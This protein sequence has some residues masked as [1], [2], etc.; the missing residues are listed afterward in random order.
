MT[1][2][3]WFDWSGRAACVDGVLY[4]ADPKLLLRPTAPLSSE[5]PATLA[6]HKAVP[7]AVKP[8]LLPLVKPLSSPPTTNLQ[9]APEHGVLQHVR[10][11]RRPGSSGS[12]GGSKQPLSTPELDRI[13]DWLTSA[14]GPAAPSPST[15]AFKV[16]LARLASMQKVS[17]MQTGVSLRL[18]HFLQHAAC[19]LP[20]QSPGKWPPAV[21]ANPSLQVLPI[22][23]NGLGVRP[24]SAGGL[25]S[26]PATR[27]AGAAGGQVGPEPSLAG[28]FRTPEMQMLGVA[29]FSPNTQ[30]S[31]S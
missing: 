19:S 25:P 8:A 2:N 31:R 27:T 7:R 23:S 12:A 18:C 20:S 30:V 24:G 14:S 21:T 29:L 4:D 9:L 28:M 3:G 13:M 22:H 15:G 6:G 26:A 11:R 1:S 5:P 16:R 17:A 10:Q